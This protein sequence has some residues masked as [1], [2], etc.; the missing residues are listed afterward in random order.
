MGTLTNLVA[1]TPTYELILPSNKKKITYRPFLVKEEKILL[2]ASESKNEKEIYKAMQDVVA[3]CTFG[4]INMTEAALV[5]IEYLFVNIRTKS[6]GETANPQIK[7]SACQHSNVVNVNLTEL[8]P[9]FNPEHNSKINLNDSTIIEM[10][11]PTYSDI[12]KMQEK[13]TDT[14]K[15]F[16]LVALCVDKIYTPEQTFTAKDVGVTDV[17]EFIESLSQSQF[18]KISSFFETMPQLT[19]EVSFKCSGCGHENT[20][21]L[22]GVADFF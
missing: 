20:I 2:I 22:K 19:K 13:K 17:T 8:N 3:A 4:K 14:E 9:D 7:C 15:M 5:D 10:R 1:T 11:C 6:V 16:T 12:E 18:R 21:T